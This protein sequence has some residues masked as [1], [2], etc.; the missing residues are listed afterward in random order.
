MAEKYKKSKDW[1]RDRIRNVSARKPNHTPQPVVVIANVT[2][3]RRSFGIFVIRSP[4]LSANQAGL[5]KNLY[6]QEVQNESIDVYWQGRKALESKGYTI[7][8]IVFDGRPGVQ[9]IFSDIPVQ[10]CHFHQKQIITRYLTKNPKLE[11]GIE[12]KKLTVTLCE[13]HESD[14][15]TWHDKW[16]SF[17]KEK[18]TDPFTGRWHYTHKQLRSA[19]RSLRLNIPYLFT[20]QKYGD[21]HI[22]TTTN[23]LDGC[24]AYLKEL[25]G[26]TGDQ[27][28]ASKTKSLRKC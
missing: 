23:F 10:M 8:A 12:L 4:H 11:A 7:Q 3:F 20:Y 15:T 2:F 16:S 1:I 24:F 27:K 28:E 26:S 9:Q 5:K 18:T 6:V 22:P 17:L 14:F 13:I 21:L 25:G 19:Y